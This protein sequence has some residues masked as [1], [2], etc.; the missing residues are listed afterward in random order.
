MRFELSVTL[1]RDWADAVRTD[2]LRAIR[3][4]RP[5]L[6]RV[7]DPQLAPWAA[8][9][10]SRLSQIE[11]V[12]SIPGALERGMSHARDEA[13]RGRLL[14]ELAMHETDLERAT[15]LA[16]G[17]VGCADPDVATLARLRVARITQRRGDL[18]RARVMLDELRAR[19]KRSD[20]IG[21]GLDVVDALQEASEGRIS[22]ALD[23][24]ESAFRWAVGNR[25]DTDASEVAGLMGN[26]LHALGD[27]ERAIHWYAFAVRH[28][29][30]SGAT[31][32]A[33][34]FEMYRGWAHHESGDR[35]AAARSYKRA[36][37]DLEELRF[38]LHAEGLRALFARG[39]KRHAEVM[40][41]A[42]ELERRHDHARARA[43]STL[44]LSADAREA[45]EVSSRPAAA[46]T[47]LRLHGALAFDA[48]SDDER[49]ALR[50]AR[51]ELARAVA[52]AARARAHL[53]VAVDGSAFVAGK[54]RVSLEKYPVLARVLVALVRG[55]LEERPITTD[56]LVA[57]GWPNDRIRADAARHRVQV[58]ISTLRVKGVPVVR[59]PAGYAISTSVGLLAKN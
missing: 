9:A 18:A 16:E 10:L 7:T 8:L 29:R 43:L 5:R 6:E 11:H 42:S 27:L 24:F 53:R 51:A 41:V 54:R 25:A 17:V 36:L 22:V 52:R 49:I 38:R 20:R 47:L 40:R 59:A 35:A 4:A 28:A 39:P 31:S 13:L 30:R 58:A 45:A 55:S 26:T 34:I 32:P 44:A 48:T 33:A 14:L 15:A 21:A 56:E 12:P 3:E 57:A 46:L 23:R 50:M 37:P 19:G 2:S 1:L